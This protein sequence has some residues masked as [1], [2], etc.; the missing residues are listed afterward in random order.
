MRALI[1]LLAA[2]L[3]VSAGPRAQAQDAV[4]FAQCEAAIATAERDAALPPGLLGAIGRVETGRFDPTRGRVRP[5]P[6]SINVEGADQV[7]PTKEAAIEAVA[8]LLARGV[9]SID[10]GCLQVNLLYHPN[11]FASLDEAF[12]PDRNAAYAARFLRDLFAERQDW[13][14]AAAAYHSR[15]P[16]LGSA[17]R[18]RVLATWGNTASPAADASP[19]PQRLGARFAELLPTA[20]LSIGAL[21]SGSR[22]APRPSRPAPLSAAPLPVRAAPFDEAGG[23]AGGDAGRLPRTLAACP[24]AARPVAARPIGSAWADEPATACRRSAFATTE[25]L[26][27]TLEAGAR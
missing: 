22:P 4:P 10:V 14:A 8:D 19:F 13:A 2:L 9:R 15:T 6:W 25:R 27:R 23:D 11:A 7:F 20:P 16:E 17:Y 3:A 26:R 21:L 1:P 24:V 12:D 5:W 18:Q